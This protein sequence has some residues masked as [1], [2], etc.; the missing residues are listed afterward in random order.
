[1]AGYTALGA[2]RGGR[3]LRWRWLRRRLHDGFRR[4]TGKNHLYRNNGNLTFTD[5]AEQA[6]VANGNDAA[7]RVGDALWFDFNNDG[8]PD[9][10][11]VRFGYSQLFHNLGNGKFEDVTKKAGLYKLHECHH[12]PSLL[13]T[14][15]TAT[16]IY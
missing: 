3:R 16:S 12:R 14:I 10:F 15:T 5:V 2:V 8:R 7:E 4:A 9:L 1:M 11:V 6:G 13:I